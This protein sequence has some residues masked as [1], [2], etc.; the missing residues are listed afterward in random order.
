MCSNNTL[1]AALVDRL[2][3]HSG[4]LNMN[5]FLPPAEP[6]K[7]LN[8]SNIHEHSGSKIRDH[9]AQ[10][11]IDIYRSWNRNCMIGIST[12]VKQMISK[13]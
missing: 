6:D 9:V 1:V 11:F 8:G 3:Y 12:I 7:E 4:V 5:N 2:T 13:N 10:F